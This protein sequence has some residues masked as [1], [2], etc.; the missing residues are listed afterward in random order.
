MNRTLP[1]EQMNTVSNTE[2]TYNE[3]IDMVKAGEV[4]S[5]KISDYQID[6]V[7]KTEKDT[8]TDL[9]L[10]PTA[11]YYTGRVYDTTLTELLLKYDVSTNGEIPD[12][13]ATVVFNLLSILLPIALLW[14]LFGYLMKKMNK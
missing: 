4:E 12:N 14:I 11:T 5:V 8:K 2:I 1:I 7:P 13:T 3:F 10:Q 9:F 6:I